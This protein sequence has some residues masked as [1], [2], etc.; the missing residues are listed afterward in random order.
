[1]GPC[2][3]LPGWLAGWLHCLPLLPA[4]FSDTWTWGAGC[5]LAV[6]KNETTKRVGTP[7]VSGGRFVGAGLDECNLHNARTA[8]EREAAAA[9]FRAA[10]LALPNMFL[11]AW[12]CNTG[13]EL[14]AS[15][16]KDGTFDLAMIEG[17]T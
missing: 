17:Y 13:D 9:G 11:A 6:F 12:G 10:R 16:M 8:D 5:S 7:T 14:F 1:M 3:H 4:W 15:L 2:T